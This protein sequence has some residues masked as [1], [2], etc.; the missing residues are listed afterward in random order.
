MTGEVSTPESYLSD[1]FL[2]NG[3]LLNNISVNNEPFKN[4]SKC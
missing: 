4:Q 2:G 3:H 1:N